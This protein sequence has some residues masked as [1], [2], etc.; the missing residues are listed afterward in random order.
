MSKSRSLWTS[1]SQRGNQEVCKIKIRSKCLVHD[2]SSPVSAMAVSR[3]WSALMFA[4]SVVVRSAPVTLSITVVPVVTAAAILLV[5]R[6]V[7]FA[8][9]VA[10]VAAR[11]AP[12]PLL[13]VSM[14]AGLTLSVLRH[15]LCNRRCP[16]TFVLPW[17]WTVAAVRAVCSG[18]APSAEESSNVCFIESA[19]RVRLQNW[20]KI[21]KGRFNVKKNVF[22]H[23]L[24]LP[25]QNLLFLQW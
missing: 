2:A 22:C 25:F 4:S 15:H 18:V 21:L 8:D 14:P 17:R 19:L 6:R 10:R 23:E 7:T 1:T 11:T 5:F 24:L 3:M 20:Y 9:F 16:A 12:C 13:F